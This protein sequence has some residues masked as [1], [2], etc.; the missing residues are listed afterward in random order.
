MD[1]AR[2]V[3]LDGQSRILRCHPLTIVLDLDQP[4]PAKFD[5]DGEAPRTGI[6]RVLHQLLDHGRRPL[7]D[8]TRRNLIGEIGR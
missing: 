5:R 1:L 2:G 8:L 6:N 7:D 3:P 4:L